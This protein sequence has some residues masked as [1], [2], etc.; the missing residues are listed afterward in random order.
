MADKDLKDAAVEPE[1]RSICTF[2]VRRAD[3][4]VDGL[5]DRITALLDSG[6]RLVDLSQHD[7]RGTL[8]ELRAQPKEGND[9]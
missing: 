9:R 3:S 7:H 4:D 6:V 5:V 8:I 2:D 1:L